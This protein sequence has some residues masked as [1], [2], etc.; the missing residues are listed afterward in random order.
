MNASKEAAASKPHAKERRRELQRKRYVAK[1]P[2]EQR[3]KNT[4]KNSKTS[5]NKAYWAI[6]RRMKRHG[7]L[8]EETHEQLKEEH[9]IQPVGGQLK[10]KQ[11]DKLTGQ[12][13]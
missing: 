2:E 8:T 1:T 11:R 5:K 7:I 6:I 4:K 12:F 9:R 13:T 3:T 10:D